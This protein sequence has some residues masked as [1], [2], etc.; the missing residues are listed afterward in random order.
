LRA[1]VHA[2]SVWICRRP[3]EPGMRRDH[4][5]RLRAN[6]GPST[7]GNDMQTLQRV[8]RKKQLPEFV[9][10][11]RTAIDDLIRAGKFPRP[12]PLGARTVGWLEADLIAWQ[13]ARI[14]ERDSDPRR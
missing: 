9:G 12:I 8:I 3:S 1:S 2:L 7:I 14:Y 6:H 5:T 10:L 11:R 13:V 4:L